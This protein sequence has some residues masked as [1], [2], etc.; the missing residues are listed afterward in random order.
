MLVA[1][2]LG[3]KNLGSSLES[4]P[5]EMMPPPP[6]WEFFKFENAQP[7]ITANEKFRFG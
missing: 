5:P 1:S 4:L 2:D 3:H 7:F 6:H